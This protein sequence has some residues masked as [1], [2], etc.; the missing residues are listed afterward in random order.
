MDFEL[1]RPTSVTVLTTLLRYVQ[2]YSPGGSC[3]PGVFGW[4]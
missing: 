2:L 4:P 1:H 3:V